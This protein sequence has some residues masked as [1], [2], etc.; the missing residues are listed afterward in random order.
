MLE[1][2]EK[3]LDDLRARGFYFTDDQIFDAFLTEYR[4]VE[5]AAQYAGNKL[6][7]RV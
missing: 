2:R 7:P 4:R 3:L 5:Q 1:Q 6:L